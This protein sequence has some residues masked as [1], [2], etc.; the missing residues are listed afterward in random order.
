MS[1]DKKPDVTIVEFE[2]ATEDELIAL[3]LE[4]CPDGETISIHEPR[5]EI[6]EDHDCTCMP[7]TLRK[8]ATA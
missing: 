3:A 6:S 2:A 5:C 8:G 4:M 7:Q 1:E